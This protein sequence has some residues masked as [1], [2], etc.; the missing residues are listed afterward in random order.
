MELRG[1]KER[2]RKAK[3]T[4]A[5]VLCFELFPED[6]LTHDVFHPSGKVGGKERK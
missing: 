4:E 6:R 3:R 5:F 1:K 2:E